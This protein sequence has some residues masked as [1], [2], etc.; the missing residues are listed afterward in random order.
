M[1]LKSH[2][3][4]SQD[5]HYHDLHPYKNIRNAALLRSSTQERT[6]VVLDRA[7]QER[8]QR[9]YPAAFAP[10]TRTMQRVLPSI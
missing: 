8:L 3:N 10:P 2:A 5:G 4:V 1:F 7:E 9:I 6:S